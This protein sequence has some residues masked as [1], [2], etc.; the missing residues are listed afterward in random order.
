MLIQQVKEAGLLA[1]YLLKA[2]SSVV[3]VHV[4]IS[5]TMTDIAVVCTAVPQNVN[6]IIKHF[7]FFYYTSIL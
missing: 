3:S 5:C 2:K 6:L 1:V 4:L 7:K